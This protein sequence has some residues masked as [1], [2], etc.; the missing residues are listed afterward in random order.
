M[1]KMG[2]PSSGVYWTKRQEPVTATMDDI[3]QLDSKLPVMEDF[4]AEA[5]CD[6]S[7]TGTGERDLLDPNFLDAIACKF[8]M[9]IIF[10]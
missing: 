5:F 6:C 8:A 10:H 3:G 4:G 9:Y 7:L 1:I 2:A